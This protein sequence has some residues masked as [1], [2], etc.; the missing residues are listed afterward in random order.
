M[1]GPGD[2]DD[3]VFEDDSGDSDVE[4]FK[5]RVR[6]AKD[7]TDDDDD[8]EIGTDDSGQPAPIVG[9]RRQKKQE[10]LSMREELQA[11]RERDA[12]RDRELAEL[13]GI[14]QGSMHRRDDIR[15][16]T[17]EDD[18]DEELDRELAAIQQRHTAAYNTLRA[19]GQ[20]VTQADKD[21]Y[22]RQVRAC[23]K[24]RIKLGAK[25]QAK[26]LQQQQQGFIQQQVIREQ[27]SREHGDVYAAGP[28]AI[29]YSRGEFQKLVALGEPDNAATLKKA[30]DATRVAFSIGRG[31]PAPTSS[32][33]DK[34][35]GAPRGGNGNGGSQT[36]PTAIKMTREFRAMAN[37]MYPDEKDDMKRY[38]MWANGPGREFLKNQRGG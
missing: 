36:G 33:K 27:I 37:A 32:Q 1:F 24:D 28:R 11:L 15:D 21:E 30:M 4:A 38:K 26:S 9:V 13:R 20:A 35:M 23:E 25:H 31:S 29:A 3:F 5:E 6:S 22:E 18:E 2:D 34:F 16:A 12:A 14:V 19:K 8:V 10:R 17:D 7:P